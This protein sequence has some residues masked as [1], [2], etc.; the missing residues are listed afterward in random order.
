MMTSR[1]VVLGAALGALCAAS[2]P[3]IDRAQSQPRS[4]SIK[5]T[6]VV[7]LFVKHTGGSGRAVVFTHAWPLSADIWDHQA[8]VLSRSGH[9]VITYDRRGFGRSSQ[10]GGGYDFDT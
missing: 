10:P 3:G 6:E 5:T 9:R 1:R 4:A 8:A 7:E 2:L